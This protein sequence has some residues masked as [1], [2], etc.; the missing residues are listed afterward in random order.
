MGKKASFW[1]AVV[2]ATAPE[3]L[4]FFKLVSSGQV[5]P[6]L[7][8]PLYGLFLIFYCFVAGM[9][10]V[11]WKPE[12]PLKAFWIGAS[13]PAIVATLIQATPIVPTLR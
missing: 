11:A 4:R 12:Q 13:I 7:N 10:S 6:N 8:W 9:V 2:G 5:L 1:W 3:I